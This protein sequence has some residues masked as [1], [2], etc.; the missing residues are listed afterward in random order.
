MDTTAVADD[1]T[2]IVVVDD[3]TIPKTYKQLRAAKKFICNICEGKYTK[4]NLYRHQS[5][6]KHQKILELIQK[7]E[8]T[9]K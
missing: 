3:A 4:Y 1:V 2:T 8:N 5:S 9:A 6:K 7:Y